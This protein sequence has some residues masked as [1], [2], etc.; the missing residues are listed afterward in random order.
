MSIKTYT[1]DPIAYLDFSID[2][3]L[4]LDTDETITV[5]TWAVTPNGVD[6]M[7]LD[8]DITDGTINTVWVAEGIAGKDYTVTNT[9]TTDQSR[10]DERSIIITC[11][12]R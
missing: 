12:Q 10:I 7:V 2:W 4:W 6:D 5:S 1:K 9:I 8:S 11:E 3:S